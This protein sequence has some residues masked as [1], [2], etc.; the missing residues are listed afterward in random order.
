LGILTAWNTVWGGIVQ[1]GDVYNWHFPLQLTIE[2]LGF[3]WNYDVKLRSIM[4]VI[5]MVGVTSDL[6]KD[7]EFF[8]RWGHRLRAFVGEK[9]LHHPQTCE[10]YLIIK[11]KK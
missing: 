9:N 8:V 5:A 3:N 10:A 4:S 7:R 6:Y 1:V 2:S 11:I